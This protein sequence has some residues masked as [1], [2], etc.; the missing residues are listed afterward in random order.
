[1]TVAKAA[2]GISLWA[3]QPFDAGA[4]SEAVKSFVHEYRVR[5]EAELPG[6]YSTPT[7]I[8]AGAYETMYM[9]ADA[10]RAGNATPGSPINEVRE[11]TRDYLQSLKDYQGLG[12]KLS[13]NEDGDAVKPT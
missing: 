2:D 9:L 1:E 7:Y 8:D 10:L 13:I 3:G 11:S 4:E 6:Q 5:V 12:N